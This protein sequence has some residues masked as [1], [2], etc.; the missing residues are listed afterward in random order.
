MTSLRCEKEK[1]ETV[2]AI[3]LATAV[4]IAQI[5]SDGFLIMICGKQRI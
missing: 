2:S 5:A 3:P 1:T 4:S